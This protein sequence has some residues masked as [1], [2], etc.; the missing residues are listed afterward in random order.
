[1]PDDFYYEW[2]HRVTLEWRAVIR[3]M[4]DV[5]GAAKQ[6]AKPVA[7]GRLRA[8]IDAGELKIPVDTAIN[9]AL[10]A[11]DKRDTGSADR[12][13]RRALNGEDALSLDGD[14][15]LDVVV[16]LGNGVRK[17]LGA[18]TADDWLVMDS[19]KYANMRAAADAYDE[20]RP[21]FERVRAA[22]MRYRTFGAA[23]AAG[24]FAL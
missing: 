19:L 8:L 7:A 2:D 23:Y 12:V 14:P 17:S 4:E 11:A 6:E 20:W 1:M 13:I 18:T 3:E 16:A 21:D 15:G 10:E 24:E 5:D 22:L 9:S